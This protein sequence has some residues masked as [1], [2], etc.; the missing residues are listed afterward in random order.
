M[1]HA[2][3][4]DPS[5]EQFPRRKDSRCRKFWVKT[6]LSRHCRKRRRSGRQSK[7]EHPDLILMDVVMPGTNGYQATRT[8]VRDEATRDILV[9]I[10]TSAKG[11]KP[12]RS[13]ACAKVPSDC[14]QTAGS[15]GPLEKIRAPSDETLHG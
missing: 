14:G 10:C 1:P 11:W 2:D 15:R 8:I 12:T 9:I 7:S 5:R 13:G 6:A 4:E 3:Q